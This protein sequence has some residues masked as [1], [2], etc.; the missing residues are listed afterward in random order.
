MTRIVLTVVASFPQTQPQFRQ[1]RA[2][3]TSP[4]WQNDI[5]S[6][7]PV[8]MQ[9]SRSLQGIAEH[10]EIEA[11]SEVFDNSSQSRRLQ[12]PNAEPIKKRA[13]HVKTESSV[14]CSSDATLLFGE[15]RDNQ[16]D[17][18]NQPI[19]SADI[20]SSPTRPVLS[21]RRMSISDLNLEPGMEATIEETNV[22]LDDIAQFI[23]GPDPIDNKWMCNFD[24]C[25][26]KF[27]RKE[28]IKSHVQTHLGDR[29]F[30]CGKCD[31][32]F[33]RGHDLKRHAKI[34]TGRKSYICDCG[35]AF[36]R[37]DALTR[38]RQRGMCIGAFEGIVRKEVKR[39]RPKKQRPEMDDRLDKATRT[40]SKKQNDQDL[41]T[42]SASS[43]SQSSWGSPPAESMDHLSLQGDQ[44]PVMTYDDTMQLF[45]LTPQDIASQSPMTMTQ[46]SLP[47][48]MFSFTPPASPGYS[49][50][51]KPSPYRELTPTDMEDYEHVNPQ[52]SQIATQSSSLFNTTSNDVFELPPMP[53][54]QVTA[55]QATSL[56]SLSHSSSPPPQ[57]SGPTMMFDFGDDSNHLR[58]ST[59]SNISNMSFGLS[60]VT[61]AMINDNSN[62]RNEFD[63]FL[64]FNDDSQVSL[65]MQ[66]GVETQDPFFATL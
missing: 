38:H 30:K 50:G 35:N 36:A 63:S 2:E 47:P 45:G 33:V 4:V 7:R 51:N 52:M 54:I 41:Y 49:T 29:Q 56:P 31:K 53:Q 43:C 8:S 23:E 60:A 19:L 6:P 5:V 64:D 18:S 39:G 27:G 12:T 14:S 58:M 28:N 42:S 48:N 21:P 57:E 3:S 44:S 15:I 59:M 62:T 65:G 25:G 22:S 11:F 26:K 16:L 1:I 17:L 10:Q 24:G 66:I 9:K 20:P 34:H 40:R 55:S 37:H 61:K 32:C 13:G 46:T